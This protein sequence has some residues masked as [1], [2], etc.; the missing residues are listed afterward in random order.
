MC[1]ERSLND[2][3]LTK[4]VTLASLSAPQRRLISAL[5]EAARSELSAPDLVP[6][7]KMDPAALEMPAG[8][9][10]EHGHAPRRPT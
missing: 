7:N 10:T 4:A 8:S 1:A 6:D 3:G 5:L 2:G 9:G